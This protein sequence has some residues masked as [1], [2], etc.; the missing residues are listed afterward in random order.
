MNR[1]ILT[2]SVALL[3]AL[4]ASS[5]L[6]QSLGVEVLSSRPELV[7][8]G[9]A[10]LRITA[11]AAPTVAWFLERLSRRRDE[12]AADLRVSD[13][14]IDGLIES[15]KAYRDLYACGD[16]VYRLLCFWA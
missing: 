12:L 16:Y 8:G 9:D 14:Q 13:A 15:G 5:A 1:A 2:A 4:G 7:S 10:L 11:Q 3:L 6:A